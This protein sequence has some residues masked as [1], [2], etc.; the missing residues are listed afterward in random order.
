MLKQKRRSLEARIHESYAHL[1]EAE[2]KL[3]DVILEFPGD[4]AAYSATELAARAGVSKAA[5]SRFF[6]RLGYRNFEE[7]RRKAREAKRWGSPLYLQSMQDL[8]QSLDAE[9]AAYM[10]D[11]QAV[12]TRTFERLDRDLVRQAS[13][14]LVSARRICVLGF[15][16]AHFLAA[17]FR[18]R[19]QQFRRNVYLLPATGET[20]G[21]SLAEFGSEDL[22]VVI[23]TRRRA[24]RLGEVMRLV[25]EAGA[26]ILYLTDPS[27][28]RTPAFATWTISCDLGEF[29]YDSYVGVLSVLR[30]LAIEASRTAGPEGR[31]HLES[32]ERY[33]EAL[34]EFD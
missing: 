24:R 21:E 1:P 32:I 18:L 30:F 17:Y 3:A 16:N 15:R 10:K 6:K 7:A 23:G 27:A 34:H 31:H 22:L 4:I 14:R 19:L 5:A 29:V 9:L 12:L 33:H 20:F 25:K 8:D 26:P 2:R 11:E 28:R 13:D